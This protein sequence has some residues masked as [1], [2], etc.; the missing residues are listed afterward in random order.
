[1]TFN[2]RLLWDKSWHLFRLQGLG[3]RDFLKGQTTADLSIFQN[4]Q[5]FRGCWLNAT[6]GLQAILEMRLDSEGA[7]VLVLAGDRNE[8]LKGFERVIFPADKVKI[9]S[10]DNVRRVQVIGSNDLEKFQEVNWLPIGETL[11]KC[12][13]QFNQADNYQFQQWR[14]E[15][16]LPIGAGEL[17]GKTNPFEL[18]LSDLVSLEK[19]CYLG[20]ETLSKISRTGSLKQEL[21]FWKSLQNVREGQV[22]LNLH[23]SQKEKKVAG[24]ITSSIQCSDESSTMGLALIRRNYL[25]KKELFIDE[26][27]GEVAISIPKGFVPLKN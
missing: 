13:Q 2:Q 12:L 9:Y 3:T 26:G 6:G 10:I 7:D 27:L 5:L 4:G 16:G 8:L 25:D 20:Q 11:P 18:G 21:R 1:M 22:L 23:F 17:D 19:G 14:L 24:I 15:K